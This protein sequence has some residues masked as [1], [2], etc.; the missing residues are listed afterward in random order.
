MEIL[1]TS[2]A[3]SGTVQIENTQQDVVLAHDGGITLALTIAF[4]PNPKDGQKVIITSSIGVTAL[5]L[6]S[7]VG[8]IVGALTTLTSGSS[9][10]YI[11]SATKSK[12]FRY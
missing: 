12:W 11:Y 3:T 2:T 5:T 8:T 4:P 7:V 10:R 9:G 1:Q 6:T